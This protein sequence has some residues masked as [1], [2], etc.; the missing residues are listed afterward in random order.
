MDRFLTAGLTKA[1]PGFRLEVSLRLAPGITALMGPSGSGKTTLLRCLAGLDRPESGAVSLGGEVWQDTSRFLPAERRSI[2]FVFKEFALFPHLT[3]LENVRYGARRDAW[4]H[5]LLERFGIAALRDRL[6]HA[7]SAGQQ[8]RVA[9]ARAIA[10]EPQLLLMDEPFS[11]L[12]P[13]LK[14]Q[15]LAELG[16]LVGRFGTTALF[17]THALDEAIALAQELAVMAEG[18]LLQKGPTGEV[19]SAP[20]SPD[21]ARLVGHRGG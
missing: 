5:E 21:V 9:I 18:R 4:A 12:D 10:R 20:A 11:S 8:Q 1:Y 19:L 16:E 2:G 3:V 15:V 6:P 14:Q 13:T 7:L 17:V